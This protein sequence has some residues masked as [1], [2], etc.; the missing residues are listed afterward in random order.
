[1]IEIKTEGNDKKGEFVIYQDGQRAGRMTYEKRGDDNQIYIEHTNVDEAFG[2][3]GLAGK[4]FDYAID[5]ARKNDLKI[6]PFCT[7]VIHKFK[8][9][10]S[11]HD[12]LSSEDALVD[13][14]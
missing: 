4:L 12:V 8:K 3:K 5:Y 10:E 7:Y 9:D 11:T 14:E 2:G 1:M 13:S 6:V